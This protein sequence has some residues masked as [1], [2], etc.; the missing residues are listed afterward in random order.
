MQMDLD[1]PGDETRPA[2]HSSKASP[3]PLN[4]ARQIAAQIGR[5]LSHY[6]TAD[7]PVALRQAQAE[8][9]LDDLSEF[10]PEIVAAA[11]RQW[12]RNETR[13]LLPAEL[14]RL[15]SD[16]MVSRQ[17]CLPKPA[18]ITREEATARAEEYA[19]RHGFKSLADFLTAHS[20]G[21]SD[22]AG[23]F[24]HFDHRGVSYEPRP[25]T[26]TGFEP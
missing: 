23:G 13:R 16:E 24:Y 19:R 11:C 3:G 8:D 15:C 1:Y 6:W 18:P 7:E 10:P 4:S 2:R 25:S 17:P 20:L 12:R 5:L 9:W 22:G 21:V 26:E 14:R